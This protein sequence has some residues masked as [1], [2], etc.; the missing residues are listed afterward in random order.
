MTE[1]GCGWGVHRVAGLGMVAVVAVT[2]LARKR[3]VLVFAI[4]ASL[5]TDMLSSLRVLKSLAMFTFL[6][7][8]L[9]FA[10]ET[11]MRPELLKNQYEVL[12]RSGV[13]F[14]R[15]VGEYR[16]STYSARSARLFA[17]I[18]ALLTMAV[19]SQMILDVFRA[20]N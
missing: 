3:S 16:L 15:G 20:M 2:M 12:A 18:A 19:L 13:P 4:C 11:A 5:A 9:R 8:T 10:L 6:A 17:T 1:S 14:F 7:I